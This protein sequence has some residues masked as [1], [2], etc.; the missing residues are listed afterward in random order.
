[1]PMASAKC[2][3]CPKVDLTVRKFTSHAE[4][5]AADLAYYKSLTP[6]ERWDILLTLIQ[7]VQESADA[8]QQGF[9]RVYRVI[10]LG[11]S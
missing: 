6:Q 8:S 9:T 2:W 1:M 7:Q 3:W 11:E 4:A 10:K 5:D